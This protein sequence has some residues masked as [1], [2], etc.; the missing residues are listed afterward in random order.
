MSKDI[1]KWSFWYWFWKLLVR[2]SFKNYYGRIQVRNVKKIPHRQPVIFVLNHQNALMDALAVLTTNKYQPVFL[3]RSDIFKGRIAIA[4]LTFLKIL[5]IYR[6]RD[7]ADQVKKNEEIFEKTLQVLNNKINPLGLMPEGNHGDKRR[8]RPLQKGVFRIAFKAQEAYGNKPGVKIQPIG[9]DFEHY[10]KFGKSLFVN[11]GDP[12]EVA[13]FFDAYAENP[14]QAM[15]DFREFLAKKMKEVMIHIQSEEY[16]HLYQNL[17]AVYNPVMRRHLSIRSANPGARFDADKKMITILD[18][19]QEK[20]SQPSKDMK[21]YI[22]GLQELNLR[23]WLFR[24]DKHSFTGILLHGMLLIAGF[25]LFLLGLINNYLPFKLPQLT[26]K[27]IKD[28][29]FHSSFKY[30]VGLILFTTY[31]LLLTLLALVFI[32]SF[33]LAFIYIALLYPSGKFA[34]FYSV[35]FK[36]MIAKWRYNRMTRKKNKKLLVLKEIRSRIIQTIDDIVTKQLQ[37]ERNSNTIISGPLTEKAS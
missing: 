4:I 28:K 9:L 36:K 24:K 15:N 5:P 23:E 22:S 32:R 21:V 34:F 1:D 35:Q 30:V 16:Y 25:P 7:G 3:A 20:L 18:K 31:Y 8:L 10:Q 33:W 13:G 29:Q 12:I 14:V 17:R 26:T 2:F 11:Y 19:N 6:I 27:R 37:E